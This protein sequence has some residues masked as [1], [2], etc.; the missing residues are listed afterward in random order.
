MSKIEK[1]RETY[2]KS[3]CKFSLEIEKTLRDL[4][5]YRIKKSTKE[6]WLY[7]IKTIDILKMYVRHFNNYLK[8]NAKNDWANGCVTGY[9]T[10]KDI[11][12][13]FR[14]ETM[15][16]IVKNVLETAENFCFHTDDEDVKNLITL[17]L[18]CGRW[19]NYIEDDVDIRVT[20]LIDRQ[21]DKIIF[22]DDAELR[23]LMV[24]IDLNNSAEGMQIYHTEPWKKE[25]V[26]MKAV[27]KLYNP[28]KYGLEYIKAN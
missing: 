1:V 13:T 26:T 25:K 10:H 17:M 24:H 15:I 2:V 18:C 6:V 12:H 28:H 8:L 7:E 11:T 22:S 4:A 23:R 5:T 21:Y 27:D 3:E 20:Q 16:T 14:A 19:D 9:V